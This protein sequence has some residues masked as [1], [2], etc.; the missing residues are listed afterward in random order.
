[1]ER[2][3]AHAALL[4]TSRVE[5][6]SSPPLRPTDGAQLLALGGQYDVR[7][8][9]TRLGRSEKCGNVFGQKNSSDK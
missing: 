1:M 6:R 7:I 2:S 8:M 5:L 3:L 4:H 9:A